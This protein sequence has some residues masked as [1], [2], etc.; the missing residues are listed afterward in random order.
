MPP[1][2]VRLQGPEGLPLPWGGVEGQI[3]PKPFRNSLFAAQ[4]RGGQ[5]G[6]GPTAQGKGDLKFQKFL[7]GQ[8]TTGLPP[9]DL[10]V[11]G[12]ELPHRLLQRKEAPAADQGLG[13]FLGDLGGTA[14]H[15]GK[16]EGT[17]P[18]GRESLRAGVDGHD[19]PPFLPLGDRSRPE[20]RVHAHQV[21]TESGGPAPE[22]RLRPR[23]KL[24]G[25]P[26]PV[27]PEQPQTPRG[28]REEAPDP[29]LAL[30]ALGRKFPHP[31]PEEGG[32]ALLKLLQGSETTSILV[33]PREKKQGVPE[34]TDAQTTQPRLPA[35]TH[36]GKAA[37][38]KL[39]VEGF[40]HGSSSGTVSAATAWGARSREISRGS[41]SSG[42]GAGAW[43]PRRESNFRSRAL[44]SATYWERT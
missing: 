1:P 28:V 41:S 20:L 22:D 29:V 9:P 42:M 27:E 31:S 37:D 38:G 2:Q 10:V 19:A 4:Y 26:R 25:H 13:Q 12:V 15:L 14:L 35:R 30:G 5:G 16:E 3:G 32:L 44:N 23:G 24:G 6:G 21:I 39:R 17:E 11:R 36:P 7:V 18:P 34:G 40:P 8:A 43:C 33:P